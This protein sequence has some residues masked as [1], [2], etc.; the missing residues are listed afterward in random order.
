MAEPIEGIRREGTLYYYGQG[1]DSGSDLDSDSGEDL[2]KVTYG[3]ARQGI[4]GLSSQNEEH[5][6]E[7]RKE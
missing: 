2:R 6:G 1:Y 7:N 4:S 3:E 5:N